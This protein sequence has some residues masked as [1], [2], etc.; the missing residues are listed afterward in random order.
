MKGLIVETSSEKG[1]LILSLEKNPVASL[2]LPAGPA[3]SQSLALTVSSFL[4]THQWAPDFIGIGEGPGSYTGVRVGA[5]LAQALGYGW[6]IPVFGFCSLNSFFTPH[7][8]SQAVVVDAK[9][10]GSYLLLGVGE[11]TQLIPPGMLQTYCQGIE[12]V[13][14]P[15]PH[16]VKAKEPLRG[17]WIETAPNPDILA[18][19]VY[20]KV[21]QKETPQVTLSYFS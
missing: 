8:N 17:I 11:T 21:I 20:Q 7:A 19:F 2:P 6:N 13:C 1:I 5:A 12:T 18:S 16:L 4:K 10:A 15:H 3:L 14:S 9:K